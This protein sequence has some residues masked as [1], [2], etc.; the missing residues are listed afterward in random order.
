[1]ALLGKGPR[2]EAARVKISASTDVNELPCQC[3]GLPGYEVWRLG[4]TMSITFV[5]DR[6]DI[7]CTFCEGLI[8][9][10]L[11]RPETVDSKLRYRQWHMGDW[12]P[13][14]LVPLRE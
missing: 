6:T 10:G 7:L 11:L 13:G 4:R 9:A 3:C 5:K 2:P 1:M 14:D 12:T 8:E